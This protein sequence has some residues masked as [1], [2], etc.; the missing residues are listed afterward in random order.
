MPKQR[1]VHIVKGNSG[2]WQV[3]I[4]GTRPVR[5]IHNT[6]AEA[7]TAGSVIARMNKSELLIRG[8]TERSAS[9]A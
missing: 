1:D 4:E 6:Q 3:R 2:G 9:A 8:E 5:S 7:A